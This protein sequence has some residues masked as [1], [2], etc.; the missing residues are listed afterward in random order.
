MKTSNVNLFI[1][2][3]KPEKLSQGIVQI[4]IVF[5]EVGWFFRLSVIDPS[6][7]ETVESELEFLFWTFCALS[8]NFDTRAPVFNFLFKS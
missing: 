2:C 6:S 5:E 4:N 7:F 8:M 3:V 1:T